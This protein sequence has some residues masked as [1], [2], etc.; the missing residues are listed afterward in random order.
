LAR[1]DRARRTS[2]RLTPIAPR[3]QRA[4]PRPLRPRG[5]SAESCRGQRA[6]LPRVLSNIGEVEPRSGTPPCSGRKLAFTQRPGY[7]KLKL[8]SPGCGAEL[9]APESSLVF[10]RFGS[11]DGSSHRMC[12]RLGS[13]SGDSLADCSRCSRHPA[14]SPSRSGPDTASWSLPRRGAE[15]SS[16]LLHRAWS[17]PAMRF[18]APCA[19]GRQG[20]V[21]GSR[22]CAGARSFVS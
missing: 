8:A 21:F 18:R 15:Q 5:G 3:D 22:E 7:G 19:C 1:S 10:M 14:S 17:L 11:R 6:M 16:A 13:E 2:P 4:G 12:R 20:E 9:R